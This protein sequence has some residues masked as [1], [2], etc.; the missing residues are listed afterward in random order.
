MTKFASLGDRQDPNQT[1]DMTIN[2]V[3]LEPTGSVATCE[4]QLNSA[5]MWPGDLAPA[6]EPDQL[7]GYQNMG[8]LTRAFLNRGLRSTLICSLACYSRLAGL[9]SIWCSGCVLVQAWFTA[10][11]HEMNLVE[12]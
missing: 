1:P 6:E 10:A 7:R 4:I 9:A 8:W 11:S 5:D 2:K 12:D 3:F